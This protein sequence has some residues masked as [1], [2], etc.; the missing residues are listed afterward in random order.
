MTDLFNPKDFDIF[1]GMTSI[2]AV[3]RSIREGISNRRI[4]KIIYDRDRASTKAR[5]LKFLTAVSSELGFSLE[6]VSADE[7]SNLVSGE[8]HGGIVAICSKTVIP[9]LD[10]RFMITQYYQW[11]LD[12]I[13][14]YRAVL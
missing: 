9:T 4:I 3:I 14:A 6:P 7:I 8:T 10:D 5:E 1:E 11:L 2:S 12:T 13:A